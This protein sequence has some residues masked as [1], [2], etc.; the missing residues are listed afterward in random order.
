MVKGLF[1]M[2]IEH[3]MLDIRISVSKLEAKSGNSET[4]SKTVKI[5]SRV[6]SRGKSIVQKNAK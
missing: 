2:V 1:N 6:L 3:K 4:F 5:L